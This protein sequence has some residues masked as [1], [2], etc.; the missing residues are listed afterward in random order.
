MPKRKRRSPRR[1]TTRRR[2]YRR[3][4]PVR[5]KG[6]QKQLTDG[7]VG[8]FQVVAGKATARILTQQ[9][10]LSTE[11]ATGIATQAGVAL[12]AGMLAHKLF[13]ANAGK[14]I[15]AGAL[16]AP[17]ESMVVNAGVPVLS[18]AL[19]AYPQLA[20]YPGAIPTYPGSV[21]LEAYP[22]TA[23]LLLSTGQGVY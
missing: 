9:L 8:A 21:Q 12:L 2:T 13:G 6:I 7:A 10:G 23:D 22:D 17:I 14:M 18:D 16:T 1:R 4:Q 3:N 11:G 19:S 20:A 15:L 5:L